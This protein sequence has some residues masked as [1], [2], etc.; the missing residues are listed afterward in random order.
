V[1]GAGLRVPEAA[2]A[3]SPWLWLI[4]IGCVCVVLPV[5]VAALSG[6]LAIPHNDAAVLSLLCL[7]SV[8]RLLLMS[9]S[10]L[11]PQENSPPKKR[12][13]PAVG[14]WTGWHSPHGVTYGHGKAGRPG[15]WELAFYRRPACIVLAPS[16]LRPA[17]LANEA[18]W[19]S[20]AP[21]RTRHS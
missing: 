13:N 19:Y 7:F 3:R 8:Y 5:L 6:D 18:A 20:P 12:R 21:T 15:G 9:L 10:V 1:T 17:A 14:E 2:A 16:P 4:A 11:A